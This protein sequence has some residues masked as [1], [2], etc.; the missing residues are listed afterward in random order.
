MSETDAVP[1]QPRDDLASKMDKVVHDTEGKPIVGDAFEITDDECP[2]CGE[3]LN[4][5]KGYEVSGQQPQ[6]GDFCMCSSCLAMLRFETTG[7]LRLL[8]QADRDELESKPDFKRRM[9]AGATTMLFSKIENDLGEESRP[10]LQ[11]LPYYLRLLDELEEERNRSEDDRRKE[12]AKAIL[13][14]SFGDIPTED[15]CD[16]E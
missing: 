10:M 14:A 5:V 4:A 6:A 12:R 8:T 15:Q 7:K 9:N 16:D 1:D 13:K 3:P 2:R 11:Q